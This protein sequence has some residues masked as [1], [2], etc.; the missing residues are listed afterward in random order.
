MT[1]TLTVVI[2]VSRPRDGSIGAVAVLG[3]PL[4]LAEQVDEESERLRGFPRLFLHRSSN[5]RQVVIASK[6]NRDTLATGFVR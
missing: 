6:N 2:S 3:L 1:L 4:G 5:E